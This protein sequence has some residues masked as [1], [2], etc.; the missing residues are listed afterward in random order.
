[1]K[2]DEFRKKNEEN[3][4]FDQY[5]NI[6]CGISSL[7]IQKRVYKCLTENLGCMDSS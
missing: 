5:S 6:G 1:M 4:Y 2:N 7:A 3:F